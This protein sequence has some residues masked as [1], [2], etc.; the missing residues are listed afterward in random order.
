MIKKYEPRPAGDEKTRHIFEPD[1]P[2][3]YGHQNEH[4]EPSGGDLFRHRRAV[5]P[6]SPSHQLTALPEFSLV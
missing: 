2:G 3:Q 6:D 1:E 5:S 4:P